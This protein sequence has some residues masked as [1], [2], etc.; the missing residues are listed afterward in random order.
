MKEI[1]GITIEKEDVKVSLLADN[2]IVYLSDPEE[3][4]QGTP[5][6]DKHFQQSSYEQN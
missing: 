2:M 1:K 4:H 3:F 5:T 6:A